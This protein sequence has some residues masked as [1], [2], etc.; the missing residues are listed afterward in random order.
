MARYEW[1]HG[2]AG[3][4]DEVLHRDGEAVAWYGYDE[5]TDCCM[6]ALVGPDGD[7]RRDGFADCDMTPL[8][9]RKMVMEAYGDD[10]E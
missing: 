6:W 10:A 7:E 8:D 3:D 9:V 2:G 1:K 4:Y 5:L